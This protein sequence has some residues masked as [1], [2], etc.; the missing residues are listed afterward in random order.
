MWMEANKTV[1]SLS[2][3]VFTK[4]LETEDSILLIVTDKGPSLSPSQSTRE[5]QLRGP[6]HCNLCL[7]LKLHGKEDSITFLMNP[8]RF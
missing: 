2:Q 4:Q 1:I 3:V 6:S 8:P 5:A 7:I